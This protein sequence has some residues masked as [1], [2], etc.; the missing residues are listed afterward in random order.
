MANSFQFFS[1]K[2][3]KRRHCLKAAALD[4]PSTN[5]RGQPTPS[6]AYCLAAGLILLSLVG[7]G[8]STADWVA[9][10]KSS[11]PSTRQ[12]AVQALRAR[13]KEEATVVPALTEA[14]L[15]ENKFV[16]RDAAK[17]LAKFGPAAQE[18][19]PAL[20]FRLQDAEPSV[21]KAAARALAQINTGTGTN[22]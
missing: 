7:C 17:A 11:D 4:Q 3:D 15:D 21:R 9:Q 12:H 6:C 8:T 2:L 19:V 14:L 22:Q 5:E 18:A 16:R 10:T 1:L 13:V 20:Q